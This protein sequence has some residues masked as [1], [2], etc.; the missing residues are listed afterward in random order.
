MATINATT[1][2]KVISLK[3]FLTEMCRIQTQAQQLSAVFPQKSEYDI[4]RSA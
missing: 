2:E 3:Q 1:S 4:S